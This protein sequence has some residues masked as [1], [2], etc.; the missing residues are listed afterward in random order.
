MLLNVKEA[1]KM[2][3]MD[4]AIYLNA[5]NLATFHLF[6]TND[7]SEYILIC[8]THL[9]FPPTQ[10]EKKLSQIIIIMKAIKTILKNFGKKL[11]LNKMLF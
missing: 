2:N 10:S 11:I 5:D 3:N 1:K 8:N 9:I 6:Q 7:T 4:Q